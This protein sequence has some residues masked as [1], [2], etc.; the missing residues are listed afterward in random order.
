MIK[1]KV[2]NLHSLLDFMW[3]QK[4]LVVFW[5]TFFFSQEENE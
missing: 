1:F 4:T 2:T 5:A 3:V